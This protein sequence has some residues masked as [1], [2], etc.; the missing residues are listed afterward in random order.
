MLDSNAMTH[1]TFW[2]GAAALVIT[3]GWGFNAPAG[4]VVAQT[5]ADMIDSAIV[6]AFRWRSIGPLRGGRSIAVSGVKG[7]PREAY[8]GA[9]GGGLWKTVDGGLSWNPVTDG[10]IK[11][12]SVG[13][14]AVSESNPDIIYIGTGEACIRGNI[15]PGDGVYKSADAGK[16]WTHI[17]FSDS[18]AIAKIRVHPTNPNIVF[19]ADFGKYG[20]P[21]AERGLYK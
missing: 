9:V 20:T 15:M 21:S 17:G 3:A 2:A 19:A 6:N 14:V 10:Q 11:S 8:F 12:S 18:D 5:S 4:R 7:R 16:T 13:A 1:R